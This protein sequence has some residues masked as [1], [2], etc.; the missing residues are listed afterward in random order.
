MTTMRHLFQIIKIQWYST[1]LYLNFHVLYNAAAYTHSSKYPSLYLT[2]PF[3]P[4]RE[5]FRGKKTKL[6]ILCKSIFLF[7]EN[8]FLSTIRSLNLLFYFNFIK[9]HP[10]NINQISGGLSRLVPLLISNLG[11]QASTNQMTAIKQF[12]PLSWWVFRNIKR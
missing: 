1:C 3:S 12:F 10:N 6:Y 4:T 8:C 7:W 11:W 5:Y 2:C 9:T